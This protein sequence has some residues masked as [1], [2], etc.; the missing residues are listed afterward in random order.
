MCFENADRFSR[1]NE[2]RFVNFEL[3]ERSNDLIIALPV[4]SG[5]ANAAV[6]DQILRSFRDIGIE[7]VHQHSKWRFGLPAL[8][9]QLTARWRFDNSFNGAHARSDV[10]RLRIYPQCFGKS[11]LIRNF[12]KCYWSF[13]AQSV[14]A[15]KLLA[16]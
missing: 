10:Y 16:R 9:S 8:A 6:D 3:F 4:S 1:L 2:K 15:L 13:I 5:F 7:I 11:K 14:Q 12:K